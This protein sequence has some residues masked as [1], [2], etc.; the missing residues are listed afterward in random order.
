MNL[1][2]MLDLN[3]CLFILRAQPN[4]LLKRPELP[5]MRGQDASRA[6][7]ESIDGL[8]VAFVL[9]KINTAESPMVP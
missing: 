6:N 1:A 8:V 3:I 7:N 5:V 4:A 9:V 2:Y